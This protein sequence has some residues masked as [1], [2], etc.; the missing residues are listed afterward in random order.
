MNRFKIVL[1]LSVFS[2]LSFT[3]FHKYYISV[4]QIEYVKEKQS[5][6]IISRIFVDDLEKGLRHNFGEDI[7]LDDGHEES[8]VD[9]YIE[10]YI[11]KTFSVSINEAP[12][13]FQFIGKE[14]DGDIVRCYLEITDIQNI[15]SFE[16][17]NKI[18][19][20]VCPDQQ[21]IIKTK[22]NSKQ[23]SLILT[24]KNGSAMLK[25]N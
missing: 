2:L 10:K 24:K 21:N 16:V 17:S 13:K 7:T 18:L 6:Q 5:V 20:D 8:V 25:F 15:N 4:T 14:Y 1:L 22:I 3:S 19:F 12:V 9:T 23:K 11:N